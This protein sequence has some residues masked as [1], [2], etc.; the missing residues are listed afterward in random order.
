M[1]NLE[2]ANLLANESLRPEAN[3]LARNMLVERL[4]LN[5]DF[6]PSEV[7]DIEFNRLTAI[8]EMCHICKERSPSQKHVFLMCR[9]NGIKVN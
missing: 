5:P 2:L 9:E 7:L 8:S 6:S 4:N 3:N 1:S